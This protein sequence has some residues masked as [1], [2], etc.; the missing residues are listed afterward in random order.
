MRRLVMVLVAALPAGVVAQQPDPPCLDAYGDPLPD[1]A[2]LR[3]GT[4]RLRP[5]SPVKAMAFTPDG[6]RLVAP[7]ADSRAIHVWD[8][9]LIRQGLKDLGLD[10][11]APPYP[12]ARKT[13]LGPRYQTGERNGIPFQIST[14]ASLGP[15][16]PISSDTTARGKI[17]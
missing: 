6:T 17:M 14:S 1:G 11:D 16:R 5:G 3:I 8:L 13:T 4:T 15:C 12:E 10:W 7:S 9:R 2:L